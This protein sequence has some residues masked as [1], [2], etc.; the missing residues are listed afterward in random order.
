M[1][2]TKF[3][4]DQIQLPFPLQLLKF[5]PWTTAQAREAAIRDRQPRKFPAGWHRLSLDN[6]NWRA[7]YN[8]QWVE[9][10]KALGQPFIIH[11]IAEVA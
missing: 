3:H 9:R 7:D 11:A 2:K 5:P 10:R 1:R 4:T 6:P 8:A